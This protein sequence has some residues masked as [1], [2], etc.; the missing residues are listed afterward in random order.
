MTRRE[1]D[2]CI[3]IWQKAETWER[4]HGHPPMADRI[5]NLIREIEIERD[6]GK[7]VHINPR[8]GAG[9]PRV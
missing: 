1:F 6:T 3:K 9:A 4:K 7:I 8:C 5:S 2:R